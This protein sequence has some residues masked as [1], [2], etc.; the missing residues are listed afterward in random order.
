MKTNSNEYSTALAF[1]AGV[2]T[3]LFLERLIAR[4][5]YK[6]EILRGI[7]KT[8]IQYQNTERNHPVSESH[9]WL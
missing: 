8:A 7:P 2:A 1:I 4:A 5:R 9:K 6:S 3:S